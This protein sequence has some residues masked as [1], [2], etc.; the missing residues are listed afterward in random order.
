M[1]CTCIGHS[2]DEIKE[3]ITENSYSSFD[4]FQDETFI[5]TGCG[6]CLDDVLKIFGL[7]DK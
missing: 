4:E 5:G 1:L 2:E 6:H 7:Y 3:M